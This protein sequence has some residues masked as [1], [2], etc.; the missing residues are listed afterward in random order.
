[1]PG[2]PKKDCRTCDSPFSANSL[3]STILFRHTGSRAGYDDGSEF[4][5]IHFFQ[6]F[7]RA[8]REKQGGDVGRPFEAGSFGTDVVGHEHVEVLLL[9]LLRAV[10]DDVR[11][12]GS[13]ADQGLMGLALARP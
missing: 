9:E 8:V 12:F 11:R 13:K 7:H 10:F 3:L 1:M 5:F 2:A 4:V 6:F